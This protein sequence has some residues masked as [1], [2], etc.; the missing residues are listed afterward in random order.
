MISLQ[1]I[2]SIQ[3]KFVNS[4][5]FNFFYTILQFTKTNKILKVLKIGI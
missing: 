2:R 1:I 3:I 5:R 4:W